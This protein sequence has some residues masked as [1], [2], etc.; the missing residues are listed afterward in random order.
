MTPST[1][2]T[3]ADSVQPPVKPV[4]SPAE[5]TKRLLSFAYLV[6]MLFWSFGYIY[7]TARLILNH[8]FFFYY[9]SG[10]LHWTDFLSYY[11]CGKIVLSPER[12]LL[13]D[14]VTQV[15]CFNTLIAPGHL[16]SGIIAQY[17]PPFCV[18]SSLF[19][20]AS[21]DISY[22]LWMTF[23]VVLAIFGLVLVLRLKN[24]SISK[25]LIFA[26]AVGVFV[27]MSSY[28]TLRT[29]QSSWLLLGC[30]ALYYFSFNSSRD[31]WAGLFLSIMATKP[32]YAV[33]FAIPALALGRFRILAWSFLSLLAQLLISCL[34]LGF[35]TILDYP[36]NLAILEGQLNSEGVFPK[37]M[38]S[39]RGPLSAVLDAALN[40]KITFVVMAVA[41]LI[42]LV[43]WWRVSR[44]N[45]K[46]IDFCWALTIV[47]ILLVSPH[48]VTGDALFL[49]LVAAITIDSTKLDALFPD[50]NKY[51][52]IWRLIFVAL[53]LMSMV[54]FIL[55]DIYYEVSLSCWPYFLLDCF[56]FVLALLLFRYSLQVEAKTL[57][58]SSG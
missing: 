18:F 14:P 37:Q 47:G 52:G 39:I 10:H 27:T 24:P 38:I 30:A 26:F 32:Q 9:E 46:A 56:L 35:Q 49:A 20:L 8:T 5:K 6:A 4:L 13:Y 43:V 40:Q 58:D 36:K 21:L 50:G 1:N 17:T 2:L 25:H 48:T 16:N 51:A 7:L 42:L 57:S 22:I 3:P 45:S 41:A 29:G 54:F 34:V 55:S 23:S 33:F 15:N 44:A 28:T 19:A 11:R 12:A 53:P 31:F